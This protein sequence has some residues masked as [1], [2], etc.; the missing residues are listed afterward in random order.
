MNKPLQD[1][2][3]TLTDLHIIIKQQNNMRDNLPPFRH[4]ENVVGV[5]FLAQIANFITTKNLSMKRSQF[6]SINFKLIN[7]INGFIYNV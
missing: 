4:Y 5:L 2:G 1:I 7:F 3:K 6:L